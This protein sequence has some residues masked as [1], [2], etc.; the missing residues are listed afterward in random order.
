MRTFGEILIGWYEVN[1]R[2]LPWR[3]TKD[4]YKIW[5]SE[6]IL[7]Q[8]RVAQGYDYYVRFIERFPDCKTLAEADEDEVLKYWQ[9]LGYYSRARYLHEAS[10][11][12][13]ERG[14]F[15]VTYEEIRALKGIGDYTA[16]A[17][18]SFAY[19]MPIAVVDGNV[20]RVISRWA[21]IEE[22]IDTVEGRKIISVLAEELLVK[23]DP[24]RYNQA[25]MDFGALQCVPSS[26]RCDVCPLLETC[27][28]YRKKLVKF[29]P[30]KRHKPNI[31]HRY[32][33]YFYVRSGEY[34]FMKKRTDKDIWRNLYECPL[35]EQGRDISEEELFALPEF[36]Q[37]FDDAH[38]KSFCLVEK[39]VKHV[40]SHQVIHADMYEVVIDE[41]SG[42]GGSFLRIPET[43]LHKFPVSR[44]ISHFFSLLLKSDN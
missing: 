41:C 4:P 7:Q 36:R 21:G 15:P 31:T 43:D 6:I 32:F 1:K 37:L 42:F 19:D 27:A 44:L 14:G 40:L 25:I 17:I 29:L 10:R 38:I 8:T 39:Q 33:I 3:E 2:D 18:C 35:I 22:P 26:P 13:C 30:K 24:A 9:G 11:S 20:C 34:T 12:V 16:S 23:S 5:I 28:A